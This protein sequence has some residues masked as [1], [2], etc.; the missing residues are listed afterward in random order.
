MPSVGV[1]AH[2][3][4]KRFWREGLP[5]PSQLDTSR[6]LSIKCLYA[7]TGTLMVREGSHAAHERFWREASAM[8][9]AEKATTGDWYLFKPGAS[10]GRLLSLPVHWCADRSVLM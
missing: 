4:H 2:A 8:P 6:I 7:T 1:H 10:D 9:E 5:C 3:A